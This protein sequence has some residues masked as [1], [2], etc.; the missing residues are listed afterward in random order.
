MAYDYRYSKKWRLDRERGITRTVDAADVR[1][2]IHT[3]QGAGWSLRSIAGTAEASVSS[4]C[5]VAKGEQ[6]KIRR[7]FAERILAVDP[8]Q[9][10]SRPSQGVTEPFV[11]RIGTVRRIQALLYMGWGHPQMTEHSGVRTALLLHQQGRWVTR[12]S[13][14]AIAAMYRDLSHR[15]GPSNKARRHA[16]QRGY[17]GPTAWDDID[18]DEAPDPEEEAS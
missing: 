15:P 8:R 4:V 5:R 2:H 12:T 18:L 10:P 17:P 7:D 1:L 13:H 3:L 6:T 9:V 16:A 14:D 11:P